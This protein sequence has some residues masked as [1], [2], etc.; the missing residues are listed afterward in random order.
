MTERTFAAD[1]TLPRVPLPTLEA[2]CHR[3]LEWCAPLLTADELATTE[4]A[5][6]DLLRPDSPARTLHAALA[7]Y[8]ATPGVGSWLDLFWPSRYLGRRDRIALNANFF[9][10]FREE[11]TLAT[12]T[13]ANQVERAA[14]IISA[15]VDYKL[16]L[17]QEAIPPVLQR[18]QALSMWQNKYLFSETRIPG[19]EQDSVR[20]PYSAEWPGP[21]TAKH[22]V[23]FFR[24]SMFRMD[25]LGADGAPYSLDDL[26]DGLREVLKAGARSTRTDS[27]VGHLT[28]KARAEWAA[29]RQA[30]LAQPANAAARGLIEPAGVW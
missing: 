29:S 21:S 1:D 20:V 24:G 10:L 4:A 28:T 14:G 13:G 5:V 2:S 16:A 19:A 15:A 7:E 3:F 18:G 27:A 22:V 30:L 11:T 26:A 23:V 8:D 9:F 6:A 25:V 12:S 17:D